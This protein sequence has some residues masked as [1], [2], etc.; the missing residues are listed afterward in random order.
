[1][2]I[3]FIIHV[4]WAGQFTA[5]SVAWR[6]KR[7]EGCQSDVR[8]WQRQELRYFEIVD[9]VNGSEPSS[10]V[11]SV[12]GD[13]QLAL[14]L[15]YYTFPRLV[16]LHPDTNGSASCRFAYVVEKDGTP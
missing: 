6:L 11:I 9:K 7:C 13:A 1:M 16:K 4:C 3:L 10:A 14:E 5:R 15:A 8:K 12:Y 2:S